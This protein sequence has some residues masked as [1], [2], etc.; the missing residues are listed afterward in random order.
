MIYIFFEGPLD[1]TTLTIVPLSIDYDNR[2][3]KEWQDVN[4]EEY[5]RCYEKHKGSQPTRTAKTKHF[6]TMLHWVKIT[7]EFNIN[8]YVKE[9]KIFFV[10]IDW[11]VLPPYP[12]KRPE[13]ND[14]ELKTYNNENN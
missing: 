9:K 7:P 8:M 13:T 10:L 6:N 4:L 11:R 12:G 14:A 2:T 5:A 3:S 1:L